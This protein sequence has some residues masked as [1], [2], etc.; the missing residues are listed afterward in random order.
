MKRMLAAVLVVALV[1]FL[2][3]LHTDAMAQTTGKQT[4][5]TSGSYGPHGPID[6]DGDGIPNHSDP[7]FK[8]PQDGSGHK[9]G[10][11]HAGKGM[12]GKGN[13][14]GQGLRN[15]SGAGSGTGTGVCDGTGPKG[16]G[17]GR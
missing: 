13:G 17:R 11:A 5:K 9:F 4:G 6:T 14:A 10:K 7:D 12:M 3:A 15:G 8:K 1:F 16:K 2:S